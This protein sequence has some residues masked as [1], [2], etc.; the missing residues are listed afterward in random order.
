MNW[1]WIIAG[2]LITF[3]GF[4]H[5]ILGD[6]WIFNQLDAVPME[7]HYSGEITKITLRWFWHV[8]SFVI[9][10]MAVLVLTMGLTDGLI[11]V[12]VFIARLLI[13][14][15]LG[16]IGTLVAVNIKKIGNLKAFPQLPL[17]VVFIMLLFLG[18][19]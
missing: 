10:F 2:F 6:K 17:F 12:E 7:T 5:M 9:F 14:I 1:Y 19:L 13:V 16:F 11:P 8:G 3:S 4:V 15:Y 18:S